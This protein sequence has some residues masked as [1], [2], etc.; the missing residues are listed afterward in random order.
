M[1]SATVFF[2]LAILFWFGVAPPSEALPHSSSSA[3]EPDPS[4][5]PPFRVDGERGYLLDS[6]GRVLLFRGLNFV[7][8]SHPWYPQVL[9][10]SAEQQRDSHLSSHA[11]THMQTLA[12]WG[13]NTI[14]LGLMW[15]GAQLS[16]TGPHM[17]NHSYFA[18]L[19]EIVSQGADT[20]VFAFLDNHQDVMSSLFCSYDGVPLF[21]VNKVYCKEL[22]KH[23]I[24]KGKK[25]GRDGDLGAGVVIGR[26]DTIENEHYKIRMSTCQSSICMVF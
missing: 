12:K 21:Y 9:L 5:Q 2:V 15:S 20:G 26:D 13:F 23:Q 24:L 25:R 17:W 10:Q 11:L 18:V 16:E 8:K 4:I 19:E 3:T 22:K 7:A 14:R 1:A 6:T